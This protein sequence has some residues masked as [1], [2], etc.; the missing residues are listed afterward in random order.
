MARRKMQ[1][2]KKRWLVYLLLLVF[3]AVV[4]LNA[5]QTFAAKE[6]P[7]P[8]F[9]TVQLPEHTYDWTRLSTDEKG[10]K[11]YTHADGSAAEVAIDISSHQGEIDWQAVA[12]DGV[13]NV[14]LRV[15][16]RGYETGEVYGD[17][18]FAENLQGAQ[19]AGLS[20]GVYFYSQAVTMEEAQAEADFVLEAIKGYE[21][22]LPVVMDYEE[23]LK[24]TSR[25]LNLDNQTRTDNAIAFCER[26]RKAGFSAMLYSTRS[27]LLNHFALNRLADYPLWVADYNDTTAFPYLFAVWQYTDRGRVAGIG[28]DVDLNLI[29]VD[30]KTSA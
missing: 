27:M 20:C 7:A 28:P 25:T 17:E 6:P 23:V 26:I 12:A 8:P 30:L 15:G 9:E 4:W 18:R 29:F 2:Q 5:R 22:R 16:S 19:A 21:L 11:R 13:N 10:R 14:F 24:P 3:V 1:K